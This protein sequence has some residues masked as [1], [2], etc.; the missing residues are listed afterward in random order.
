MNYYNFD[1]NAE[2]LKIS[3]LTLVKNTKL[4]ESKHKKH[5]SKKLYD[6]N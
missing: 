3:I 6:T 5:M 1:K 4:L 2:K